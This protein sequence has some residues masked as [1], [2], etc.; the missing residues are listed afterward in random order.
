[1]ELLRECFLSVLMTTTIMT[2]VTAAPPE[3]MIGTL[4]QS[5]ESRKEEVV[6]RRVHC[7]FA[8]SEDRFV[9]LQFPFVP[10]LFNDP[11]SVVG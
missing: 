8:S 7:H 3:P 1:M 4:K 10:M 5:R 2:T 6:G 9:E 11:H